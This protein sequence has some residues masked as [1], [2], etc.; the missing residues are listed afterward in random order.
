MDTISVTGAGSHAVE[1]WNIDGLTI[2]SVIARNVGECGLLLQNTRNANV[3]NCLAFLM[4]LVE[5]DTVSLRS[6]SLTV[7]MWLLALDMPHYDSPTRMD[8][9]LT[10]ATVPTSIST[11]SFHVVVAEASFASLSPVVLKSITLI[12]LATVTMRVSKTMSNKHQGCC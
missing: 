7:T 11:K 10:A 2:N 9:A 6:V 1:T 5:A 3:S 4:R 8:A 12:S